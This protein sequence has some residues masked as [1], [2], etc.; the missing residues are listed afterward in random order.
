MKK[1]FTTF[2]LTVFFAF[3]N[4][5]CASFHGVKFRAQMCGDFATHENINNTVK[6]IPLTDVEYGGTTL[7]KGSTVTVRVDDIQRE[8]RFHRNAFFMF[9]PVKVTDGNGYISLEDCGLHG[10]AR[11]FDKLDKKDATLT[12]V[13]IVTAT[14][15]G[16]FL[17]GIDIAYYFT[18]GAI[19]NKKSTNRFKSGVSNAYDNSI[20]WLILKGKRLNLVNGDMI[21]VYFGS[22]EDVFRYQKKTDTYKEEKKELKKR[23]KG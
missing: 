1:F 13:E 7:K 19:Q 17:P 3:N 5:A 10:M 23:T 22:S 12:G 14:A 15:A 9:T 11:R 16:F 6:F 21:V 18:K 8:K 2:A 4:L 20:L